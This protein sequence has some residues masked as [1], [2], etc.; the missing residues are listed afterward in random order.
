MQKGPEPQQFYS[1]VGAKTRPQ[2]KLE[3][4]WLIQVQTEANPS[5]IIGWCS[6]KNPQ[7]YTSIGPNPLGLDFLTLEIVGQYNCEE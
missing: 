7:G 1:G 2:C 3:G 5:S 4:M 6:I